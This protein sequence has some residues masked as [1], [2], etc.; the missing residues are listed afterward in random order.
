MEDC[1]LPAFGMVTL[2]LSLRLQAI[3]VCDNLSPPDPVG[4]GFVNNFLKNL[5]KLDDRSA[6]LPSQ[7]STFPSMA[8]DGFGTLSTDGDTAAG[9]GDADGN[10]LHG[11]Q[12][13]HK[14]NVNLTTKSQESMSVFLA[15]GT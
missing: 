8:I 7:Y 13:S 4:F 14:Q 10:A 1:T 15:F 12:T 3:N 2:I 6:P 5:M 9:G 11:L